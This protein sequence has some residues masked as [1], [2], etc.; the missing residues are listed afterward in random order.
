M[1]RFHR[2]LVHQSHM[3]V[4]KSTAIYQ[5]LIVSGST[6]DMLQQHGCQLRH[7]RLKYHINITGTS[8]L[9]EVINKKT[10]SNSLGF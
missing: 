10:F 5:I 8:V 3:N 6:T 1:Q 4:V 7:T 9:L 2:L